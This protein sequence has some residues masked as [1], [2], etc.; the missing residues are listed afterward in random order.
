MTQQL[1]TRQSN[2]C[3]HAAPLLIVALL[4]PAT[5]TAAD[6]PN[7]ERQ[8]V[9]DAADGKLD[10]WSLLEASL[11]ASGCTDKTALAIYQKRFVRTLN[12]LHSQLPDQPKSSRR[13]LQQ[14]HTTWLT[15]RFKNHCNDMRVTLQSGDYNC[16]TSTT[17]FL[18]LVP[19]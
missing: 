9:S 15:G 5:G 8:L 11:I 14:L 19:K 1:T 12:R 3:T 13:V 17:L 7:L 10:D 6:A 16:V 2:V 18:C 4:L